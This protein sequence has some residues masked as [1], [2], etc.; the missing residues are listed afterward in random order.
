MC[1]RLTETGVARR[2]PDASDFHRQ[3][4]GA[5]TAATAF[6]APWAVLAV[7]S[8]R[9]LPPC[10][11][12]HFTCYPVPVSLFLSHIPVPSNLRPIS[13]PFTAIASGVTSNYQSLIFK[14]PLPT[15]RTRPNLLPTALSNSRPANL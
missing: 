7:R 1:A 3:E 5:R 13:P 8:P 9:N 6:L 14:V 10:H 4:Q 12:L 15:L 11:F 2:T